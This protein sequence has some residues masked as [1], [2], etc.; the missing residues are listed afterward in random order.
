MSPVRGEDGEQRERERRE[1]QISD[2]RFFGAD[3]F[4]NGEQKTADCVR[5]DC[6][7]RVH[8]DIG[9]VAAYDRAGNLVVAVR[10][11]PNGIHNAVQNDR[12]ENS[13]EMNALV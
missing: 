10:E 1:N 4:P 3:R 8:D 2:E 9:E 5:A 7:D 6:H 12:D 13:R 11:H